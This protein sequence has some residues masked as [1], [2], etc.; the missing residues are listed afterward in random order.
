VGICN[1]G[2]VKGLSIFGP[3]SANW[4]TNSVVSQ[5]PSSALHHDKNNPPLWPSNQTTLFVFQV[6]IGHE[7]AIHEV[8]AISNVNISRY[9]HAKLRMDLTEFPL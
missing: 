8:S 5:T 9:G 7:R 6:G 1:G 2:V 3:F 4:I